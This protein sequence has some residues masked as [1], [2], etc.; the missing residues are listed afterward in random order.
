M[1]LPGA[2]LS[3]SYYLGQL[4]SLITRTHERE[5]GLDV[6]KVKKKIKIDNLQN[7]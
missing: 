4:H 5:I 1:I 6:K 7:E 3:W 2:W